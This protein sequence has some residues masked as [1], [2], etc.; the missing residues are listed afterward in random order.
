[1]RAA[2]RRPASSLQ[3]AISPASVF[4]GRSAHASPPARIDGCAKS[5][6][7]TAK[8][9]EKND[10][11]SLG[12]GGCLHGPQLLAS[13]SSTENGGG[14]GV[15]AKTVGG[16]GRVRLQHDPPAGR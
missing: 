10:R 12:A 3:M 1:M 11:R 8:A 14:P 6:G 15:R 9:T 16:P 5:R 2:A 13:S 7:K 4:Q